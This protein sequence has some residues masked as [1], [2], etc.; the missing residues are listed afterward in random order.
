MQPLQRLW[1]AHRYPQQPRRVPRARI[2]DTGC[3]VVPHNERVPRFNNL[4]IRSRK[5]AML[6]LGSR[7][8][9][10][11]GTSMMSCTGS[12][13]VDFFM[14]CS[15]LNR[16]DR[17]FGVRVVGTAKTGAG[18]LC[19]RRRAEMKRASGAGRRDPEDGRENVPCDDRKER[20][21]GWSARS[22]RARIGQD[23]DRVIAVRSV[24]DSRYP[25]RMAG[26]GVRGKHQGNEGQQDQSG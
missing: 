24:V 19:V 25:R 7:G 14:S 16:A 12:H 10:G 3:W 17:A 9:N 26:A 1:K 21:I 6:G 18:A 13:V 4:P 23:P 11:G 20:H 15:S 2:A 22:R 5:P 8:A